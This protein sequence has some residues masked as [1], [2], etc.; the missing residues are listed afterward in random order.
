MKK[1]IIIAALALA[2]C[3]SKS[4]SAESAYDA[5]KNAGAPEAQLCRSAEQVSLAYGAEGDGEAT[6][7]WKTYAQVH[8]SAAYFGAG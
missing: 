7:R 1:I 6:E 2:G 5:A 4:D 3:G 8:C